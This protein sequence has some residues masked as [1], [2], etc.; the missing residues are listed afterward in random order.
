MIRTLSQITGLIVCLTIFCLT[1]PADLYATVIHISQVGIDFDYTGIEETSNT[2]PNS[3]P[4]YEQPDVVGN[5]LLF[6]PNS[7][8]SF[9]QNGPTSDITDVNLQFML[10]S[11]NDLPIEKLTIFEEGDWTI[12]FP[13]PNASASL[14]LDGTAIVTEIDNVMAPA[15]ILFPFDIPAQTFTAAGTAVDWNAMTMVDFSG[16]SGKVTKLVV[17]LDNALTT[18]V[19]GAGSAFIVKKTITFTPQVPEPTGLMLASLSLWGLIRFL[20]RRRIR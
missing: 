15:P 13:G 19:D 12:V 5:T 2:D 3:E 20:G 1:W 4:H 16:V 11:K 10:E 18:A 7:F 6:T 9:S 14:G 17:T 8:A